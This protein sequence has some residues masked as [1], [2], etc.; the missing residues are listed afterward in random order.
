MCEGVCCF[1]V[2][3]GVCCVYAYMHVYIHV[4][5]LVLYMCVGVECVYI[6]MCVHVYMIMYACT[7]VFGEWVQI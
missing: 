3:K 6:H 4:C 5:E 1:H 7:G 2:C